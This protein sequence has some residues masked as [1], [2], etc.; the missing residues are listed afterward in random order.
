MRVNDSWELGRVLQFAAK[1]DSTKKFSKG[2]KGNYVAVS[3][4]DV[5]VVCS[6]YD[7]VSDNDS[8]FHLSQGN[9]PTYKPLQ[10]DICS[11]PENGL[12]VIYSIPL[13]MKTV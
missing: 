9:A 5:G 4:K 8:M 7:N 12:E 2:Y 6:W 13:V 10:S 11:I 3:A 1:S